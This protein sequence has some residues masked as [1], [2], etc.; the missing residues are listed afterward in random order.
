KGLLCSLDDKQAFDAQAILDVYFERWEIENSY[1]EIKH[2]MLEDSIL[3]RSQTVDGVN[4]ELWGILL[5]YN[6]IRVEISRIAKEAKVS[7]LRISFVMALRDIQDEILWCA[8]ASPGSI[9]KKLRAMR[10]RVKRYILP[11][12][13]KRPKSRTVRISKTRYTIKSKHA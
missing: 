4:Q 2:R 3:L 11:E 9:P 12:K 6:L 7:P 10:E 1:G 8:I 13:R 5:A